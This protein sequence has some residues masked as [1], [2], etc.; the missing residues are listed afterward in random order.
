[1]NPRIHTILNEYTR[2]IDEA[3]QDLQQ[4]GPRAMVGFVQN[5]ANAYLTAVRDIDQLIRDSLTDHAKNIEEA[6]RK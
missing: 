6:N 3:N 4:N 5:R 1:M 2:S